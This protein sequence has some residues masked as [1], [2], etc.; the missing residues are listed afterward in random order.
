MPIKT[1]QNGG[2]EEREDA[3]LEDLRLPDRAGEEFPQRWLGAHKKLDGVED[4]HHT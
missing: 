4:Q 3:K 1:G 2:V